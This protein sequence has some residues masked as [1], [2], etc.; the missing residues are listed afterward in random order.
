VPQVATLPPV[1]LKEAARGDCRPGWMFLLL[2]TA[3]R[4]GSCY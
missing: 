1:E 2:D 3:H 4:A